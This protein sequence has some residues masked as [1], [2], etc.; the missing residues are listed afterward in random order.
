MYI[1]KMPFAMTFSKEVKKDVMG[2]FLLISFCYKEV[3]VQR[4][5]RNVKI[6]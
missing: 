4:V 3:R 1:Q 2:M 6:S 5:R